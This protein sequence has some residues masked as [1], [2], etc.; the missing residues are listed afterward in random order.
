[1]VAGGYQRPNNPA[2][3]PMPGALS[4]RTDGGP[5]DPR[6]PIRDIPNAAYGEQ[7][8]FRSDEAGA[9]MAAA[10]QPGQAPAPQ[11]VDTSHIVPMGAPTQSPMEPVTAGANAGPGPNSSALGLGSAN[12][13]AVRNLVDSLPA[14]EL[15]ANDPSS[16]FAFKQFVRRLR[17]MV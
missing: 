9:P 1:M 12:D 15:M 5:A 17:A 8:T 3:A 10:P 6:Q 2:P 4:K 14:L 11:P 7:Q 13:P 16:G